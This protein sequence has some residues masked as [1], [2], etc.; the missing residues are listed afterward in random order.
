MHHGLGEQVV[1][2]SIVAALGGGVVDL[3]QRLGLRPADRLMLDRGRRQDARAPGGVVG[4]Q[5]AGK[6]NA[7]PGGG[8]FAG[9]HAV[10]NDGQGKGGGIAAGNIGW[11]GGGDR[12]GSLGVGADMGSYSSRFL[13]LGQHLTAGVNEWLTIRNLVREILYARTWLRICRCDVCHGS[14]GTRK[15][16]G[17]DG[18]HKRQ[19]R[20][21]RSFCG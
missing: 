14:K 6:M 11:F 2:T 8:P 3:E 18:R 1:E 16:A 21:G 17:R 5:R 4:I 19:Y 13:V 7:A 15:P 9:D 20:G 10:A 12:F